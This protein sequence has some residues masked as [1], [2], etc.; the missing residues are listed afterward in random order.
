MKTQPTA[1]RTAEGGKTQKV[2][3]IFIV[4]I[5][6]SKISNS[7]YAT[8]FDTDVIVTGLPVSKGP[9]PCT[10]TAVSCKFDSGEETPSIA[11]QKATFQCALISEE[12]RRYIQTCPVRTVEFE[13]FRLNVS[14]LPN[15]AYATDSYMIFKGVGTSLGYKD[16]TIT[17]PCNSLFQREDRKVPTFRYQAQCNVS[18]FSPRCTLLKANFRIP[19]TIVSIDAYNKAIVT[20]LP[21][22]YAYK[23]NTGYIEDRESGEVGGILWAEVLPG[24]AVKLWLMNLPYGLLAGTDVIFAYEGC[25]GSKSRCIELNNLPN[26]RGTPYVPIENPVINGIES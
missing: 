19:A 6:T 22:D 8:D 9:D 18:L 26:F 23:Y 20:D 14:T 7:I 25:D 10:F 21:S 16:Q 5:G 17:L 12:I 4:K 11:D 3:H 2:A 13:A 1:F 24:G 15:A